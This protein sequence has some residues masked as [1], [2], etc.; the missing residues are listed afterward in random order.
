[1][2]YRK[3]GTTTW[4]E[5]IATNSN[6]SIDN[7]LSN[8]QYEWRVKAICS[9]NNES[10]FVNGSNFTTGEETKIIKLSGNMAYGEVD[11]D[12]PV[13]H[14]LLIENNGNSSL[15]IYSI[16]FPSG[17]SIVW[18]NEFDI[19]QGDSKEISIKFS[20][21]EAKYYSGEIV[22]N[23]DATGGTNT[24]SVSGTGIM[25]D[26]PTI[27]LQDIL[28]KQVQH[29]NEITI[30]VR[31]SDKEGDNITKLVAYFDKKGNQYANNVGFDVLQS[32][33]ETKLSSNRE[34]VFTVN[35][36]STEMQKVFK[37]S[38]YYELKFDCE[39]ENGDRADVNPVTG[40]D[41]YNN[42]TFPFYYF[43]LI[44][45]DMDINS[46]AFKNSSISESPTWE[47]Y[48]KAYGME[49][50]LFKSRHEKRYE[51]L[52]KV[53]DRAGGY[54]FG[55]ATSSYV[56]FDNPRGFNYDFP[57]LGYEN[58][59]RK[60]SDVPTDDI[61]QCI[62]AFWLKQFKEF[63][64]ASL[65]TEV[66]PTLA[67]EYQKSENMANQHFTD[68]L[69]EFKNVNSHKILYVS[70][71][72]TKIHAITPIRIFESPFNKNIWHINV[73]DNNYPN[74]FLTVTLNKDKSIWQYNAPYYN[75]E[76]KDV[77]YWNETNAQWR[78][79]GFVLCS[80][81][82]NNYRPEF[83]K[84]STKEEISI[85]EIFCNPFQN[86][87][88][89]TSD[90]QI[91]GYNNID[92]TIV[93][94]STDIEPL[95]IAADTYLPPVAYYSK[96]DSFS[97][98]LN[99]IENDS[100]FLNILTDSVYFGYSHK[101]VEQGDIDSLHFNKNS[102]LVVNNQ[103]KDKAIDIE[104]LK[105]SQNKP[106]NEYFLSD[107]IL[108]NDSIRIETQD[109]NL[110]IV[111]NN[112]EISYNLKV[113]SIAD[114]KEIVNNYGLVSIAPDCKQVIKPQ[115]VGEDTIVKID[116]DINNDG[117]IDETIVLSNQQTGLTTIPA[118]ELLK[119]YPNPTNGELVL[120][121]NHLEINNINEARL[122]LMD[123]SGRESKLD[124]TGFNN[125]QITTNIGSNKQGVYFFK[126]YVNNQIYVFKVILI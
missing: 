54:C 99:N 64:T 41:G 67:K 108:N 24:I 84:K 51:N 103:R 109:N 25:N 59:L 96:I 14:N 11:V 111:S 21:T 114:N 57:E 31:V 77:I 49:A 53:R 9:T 6:I 23:S 72:E 58:S 62:Q 76:S 50:K 105:F 118:K 90:S 10:G 102:M 73:Y 66:Y 63:Y 112:K 48:L 8:T 106:Q 97:V 56:A 28:V 47:S 46:W 113:T 79:N 93:F 123:N 120:K 20:P 98:S 37:E 89:R 4:S 116:S 115:I 124:I 19:A 38:R 74:D 121:I 85:V 43:Y 82:S 86:I 122:I 83:N 22:V 125:D 52:I 95:L 70:R 91:T 61:E 18:S 42:K 80:E 29:K 2:N 17:Y 13:W 34:I 32:L 30:T 68:L 26:K 65:L 92:S 101:K 88:I 119:V 33:G 126:L 78:N 75:N 107:L 1:M 55:F 44:G 94:N 100:T 45:F 3:S 39:T 104:I 7:L 40:T 16:D 87:S 110:A 81:P 12:T 27:T 5:I 71:G 60:L 35:T 36:E 69:N 117:I 15:H